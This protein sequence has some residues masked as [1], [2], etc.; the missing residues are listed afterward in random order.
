MQV[1][2]FTFRN[3]FIGFEYMLEGFGGRRRGTRN[4][5]EASAPE[6]VTLDNGKVICQRRNIYVS[7][8]LGCGSFHIAV[9]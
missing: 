3:T 2:I 4:F 7:K 1:I 6:P 9:I 5:S 8:C